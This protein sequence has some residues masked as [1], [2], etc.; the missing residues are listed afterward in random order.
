MH[1]QIR[2][3]DQDKDVLIHGSHLHYGRSQQWVGQ[4]REAEDFKRYYPTDVH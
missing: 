3:L 2:K 1:Q 4:I